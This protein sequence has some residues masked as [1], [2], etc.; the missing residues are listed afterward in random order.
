[1]ENGAGGQTQGWEAFAREIDAR[2][3]GTFARPLRSTPLGSAAKQSVGGKGLQGVP[4]NRQ[5]R[6]ISKNRLRKRIGQVNSQR[7]A[8]VDATL[9]IALDLKDRVKT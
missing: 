9:M 2:D 4:R 3:V 8:F 6:A 5:E 1:M 7:M